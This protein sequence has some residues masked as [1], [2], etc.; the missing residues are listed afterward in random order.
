VGQWENKPVRMA[1][2]FVR[3]DIAFNNNNNNKNVDNAVKCK[4]F[5]EFSI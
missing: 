4:N 2:F 1:R 3:L 5:K